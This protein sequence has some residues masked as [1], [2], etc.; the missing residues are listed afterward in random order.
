M[1]AV[2]GS[3]IPTVDNWNQTESGSVKD[4][5]YVALFILMMCGSIFALFLVRPS[6]VVRDDG[7]K[8]FLHT[9]TSIIQ[10]MKNLP[11]ALR[12]EPYIMLFF[13]YAFCGLWYIPYQ[14][15]DYNS[16][17]FNVPGR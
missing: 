11:T 16:Y 10:E 9:S 3:I 5:T 6:K 15:N 12:R 2:I 13:P 1:G 8:V 4:G 14:S 17:F 7:S